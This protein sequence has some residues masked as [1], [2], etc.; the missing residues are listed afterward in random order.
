MKQI[1]PLSIC[2][3]LSLWSLA[4]KQWVDGQ[5]VNSNGDTI[6][7]TFKIHTSRSEGILNFMALQRKVKYEDNN[8]NR[9][10]LKPAS[11]SFFQFQYAD[12]HYEFEPEQLKI[13][14]RFMHVAQR[15]GD[16]KLVYFYDTSS[17]IWKQA[18]VTSVGLLSG[19]L[20][21]PFII[22]TDVDKRAGMKIGDQELFMPNGDRDIS[23][24]LKKYT[25][26]CAPFI[27]L[28]RDEYPMIYKSQME[29]LY[30][31]YI[32]FCQG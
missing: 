12:E 14:T 16:V 30:A 18:L 9:H 2:L 19:F 28:L 27:E 3:L 29:H 5:F 25:G 6:D 10:K 1:L 17:N 21:T 26:K 22:V 8:G 20:L 23:V 7:C 15:S 31:K 24:K 13:R 11:A 4:K 32:E